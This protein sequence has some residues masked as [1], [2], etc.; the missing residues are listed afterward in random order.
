MKAEGGKGRRRRKE[1]EERGRGRG[2]QRLKEEAEGRGSET[3]VGR[4]KEM[5]VL[6][7]CQSLGGRPGAEL[8]PLLN[9]R[10]CLLGSLFLHLRCF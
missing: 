5:S 1:D 10:S 3:G 9:L 2:D 8:G 7:V 4:Q 6:A